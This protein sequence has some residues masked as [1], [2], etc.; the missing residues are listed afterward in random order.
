M[1]PDLSTCLTLLYLSQGLKDG[2]LEADAKGASRSG[3]GRVLLGNG[4]ILLSFLLPY[5]CSGMERML[6]GIVE[7]GLGLP[8]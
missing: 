4:M 6:M 8:L 1:L 3:W 2:Y 5:Q 7:M